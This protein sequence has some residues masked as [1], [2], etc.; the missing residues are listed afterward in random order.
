MH[1]KDWSDKHLHLYSVDGGHYELDKY[2]QPRFILHDHKV[3]RIRLTLEEH[4]FGGNNYSMK[5]IR[6]EYAI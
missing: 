3:E 4:A 5:S 1:G 2:F 6:N